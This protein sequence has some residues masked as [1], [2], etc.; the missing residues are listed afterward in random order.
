MNITRIVSY[1]TVLVLT[2]LIAEA[3]TQRS[4]NDSTRIVQQLQQVTAEKSKLQQ[5]ND[6]LKKELDELKA[7]ATQAGAEQARLQQRARELEL[8]SSRLQN[9]T[10]NNDEAL[11]K[12]RTQLQEL[13]GKFRETAQTLKD[14]ETERDVLRTTQGTKERELA[15]CVDKNAQLYLLGNE[16][17]DRMG[18]QGVWSAL[19]DK[20]PFTRL[21]RTRL[22]NLIDD[23]RYRVDELKLG[24]KR[25]ST[26]TP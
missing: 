10:G 24:T 23:Y 11:E 22:E 16:V 6:A 20:E 9:K 12:S 25:V 5:D 18:N 7:K 1:A 17:L 8:A 15:T 13:I 19:T 3:Q 26:A 14:V 21:S 2:S 4:G